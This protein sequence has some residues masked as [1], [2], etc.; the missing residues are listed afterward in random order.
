MDGVGARDAQ[1]I[2]D[3]GQT[4]EDPHVEAARRK[5]KRGFGVTLA[6]ILLL[7][8][9]LALVMGCVVMADAF[10]DCYY[11]EPIYSLA[12]HRAECREQF[13][14]ALAVAGVAGSVCVACVNYFFRPWAK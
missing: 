3:E 7:P 13:G 6:I 14:E 5:T 8:A 12:S 10:I 2:P 4:E 9:L 1:P 11:N